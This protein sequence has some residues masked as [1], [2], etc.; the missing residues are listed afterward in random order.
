[1]ATRDLLENPRKPHPPSPRRAPEPT[2]AAWR[3]AIRAYEAK[4]IDMLGVSKMLGISHQRASTGFKMRQVVPYDSHGQ[5]RVSEP[6]AVERGK[7]LWRLRRAAVMAHNGVAAVTIKAL[8]GLSEDD[9]K[10]ALKDFID[11]GDF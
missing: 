9:A 11:N 1:M 7:E 3:K 8:T 6:A 5:K 10:K 2:D 4:Q